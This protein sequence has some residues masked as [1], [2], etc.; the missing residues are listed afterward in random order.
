MNLKNPAFRQ[1]LFP[2]NLKPSSLAWWE[3][4][5][6][7]SSFSHFDLSPFQ[8]LD[9]NYGPWKRQTPTFPFQWETNKQTT[10]LIK[11]PPKEDALNNDSHRKL[12]FQLGIEYT[13]YFSLTWSN[14]KRSCLSD[15]PTHL[16]RQSAPFLIKKATLLFPWLHS[17]ARARATRVFP[18]PGGP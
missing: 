11:Y 8:V 5:F 13:A 2:F 7:L 6:L 18:V 9:P 12:Q 17:L 15:S 16:L 14:N 3:A 4:I 1:Y 10:T